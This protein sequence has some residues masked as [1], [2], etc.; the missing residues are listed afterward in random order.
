[1]YRKNNY[2]NTRLELTFGGDINCVI[3]LAL[4]RSNSKLT[5][6]SKV[7]RSLSAYVDQI[8]SVDPWHLLLS[9]VLLDM[10]ND[11]LSPGSLPQILSEASIILLLK[12]D[13]DVTECVL[14][15]LISLLNSDVKILARALALRLETTMHDVIM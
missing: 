2:F 10:F 13:K 3:N 11:S 1:M 14:Y 12:P 8:G 5:I 4:E 9:T 6:P 7:A 15:R